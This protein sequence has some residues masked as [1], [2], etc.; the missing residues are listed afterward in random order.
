[1]LTQYLSRITATVL[2]LFGSMEISLAQGSKPCP[3]VDLKTGVFLYTG[4]DREIADDGIGYG[5]DL[6]CSFSPIWG[7]EV[8]YL[9]NTTQEDPINQTLVIHLISVGGQVRF[10]TGGDKAQHELFTKFGIGGGFVESN[11]LGISVNDGMLVQLGLG[12]RYRVSEK[13]ALGTALAVDTIQSVSHLD[14]QD[15]DNDPASV[16]LI[17]MALITAQF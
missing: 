13:L 12:Y 14:D 11:G 5:I 9:G 15:R 3:Y 16:F 1:M 10:W 2:L 4:D 7:I 8:S 17:P 6:G